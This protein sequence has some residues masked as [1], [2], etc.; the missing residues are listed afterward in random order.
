MNTDSANSNSVKVQSGSPAVDPQAKLEDGAEVGAIMRTRWMCTPAKW[1]LALV[2]C[3]VAT[4]L[5]TIE[6]V[7]PETFGIGRNETNSTDANST[8]AMQREGYALLGFDFTD[9]FNSTDG[10]NSTVL[11]GATNTTSF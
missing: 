7:A 5:I 11:N 10:S 4:A 9:G 6:A 2:L 3:I 1:I 8:D